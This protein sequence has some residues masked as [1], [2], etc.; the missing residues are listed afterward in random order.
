MC[1]EWLLMIL[2]NLVNMLCK[3]FYWKLIVGFINVYGIGD[4]EE[5]IFGV[6]V[7][8]KVWLNWD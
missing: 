5:N 4:V 2:N 1:E 8:F 3:V 7:S 6:E